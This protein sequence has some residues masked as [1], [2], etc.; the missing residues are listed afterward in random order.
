MRT[1]ACGPW[2]SAP[3]GSG[4]RRGLRARGAQIDAASAAPAATTVASVRRLAAMRRARPGRHFSHTFPAPISVENEMDEDEMENGHPQKLRGGVPLWRSD[5]G[6]TRCVAWSL[7][8]VPVRDASKFVTRNGKVSFTTLPWVSSPGPASAALDS[9]VRRLLEG[10]C[11][12]DCLG[13]AG[14]GISL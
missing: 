4:G 11:L 5:V 14:P 3:E 13:R 6:T 8:A 2:P 1:K 10:A 12:Y 9:G 7:P